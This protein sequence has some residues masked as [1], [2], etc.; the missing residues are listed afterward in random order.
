MTFLPTLREDTRNGDE[1]TQLL[2]HIPRLENRSGKK[3]EFDFYEHRKGNEI[4]EP[5][6]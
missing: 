4:D 3:N 5:R 6:L 1:K 2:E